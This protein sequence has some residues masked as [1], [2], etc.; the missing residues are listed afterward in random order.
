MARWHRLFP[1]RVFDRGEIYYGNDMVENI[2]LAQDQEHFTAQ[3]QGG[4]GRSYTVTGR[5]RLDGRASELDCNCPWA[6]KGHRCK[7][8]VAALLAVENEQENEHNVKVP[9]AD[10]ISEHLKQMIAHK[11]PVLNPLNLIG[12]M[13]FTKKSYDQALE[14]NDHWSISSC[15]HFDDKMRKYEYFW[16]IVTEDNE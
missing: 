2:Q 6:N 9:F 7:H 8:E 1:E 16:E 10:L 14:L 15:R 11:S 12:N 3:V 4:I 13:K 5:L